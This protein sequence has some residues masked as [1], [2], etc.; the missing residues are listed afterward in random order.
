MTPERWQE[1]KTILAAALERPPAERNAYLDKAC[2]EPE[3]RREV[4]L[5][6]AA[7]ERAGGGFLERSPIEAMRSA[8]SGGV[9]DP[10]T[11]GS[12]LGPY[13]ILGALGAG[14]MGEVYRARDTRLDRIVA[15]KVLSTHLADRPEIRERFE[16]EARTI[17][18]LNHSHICT[19][20][21][22]G[23][24][25]GLDFLV[26][27]YVEGETL[28]R[29]LAKGALPQQQVVEFGTQIADALDAAHAKGIIHRDIKP[30]NVVITARGRAKILDFGLAKLLPAG[31]PANLSEMAT[32]SGAEQLTRPGTLIGTV[33]YMSPEQVRGEDLDARSD[34]FSFGAVL[35]EMATGIAPFRGETGGVIVEA[36]LNRTPV[37]P[38][39]LN[40]DISPKLEEIILKALEKD[41]RLRYQHASEMRTDLQRLKRDSDP[42]R[43]TIATSEFPAKPA[44]RSTRRRWLAVTGAAALAI[45][46][47]AGGWFFFFRNTHALN[48]KDAIVLADFAN[49]TGDPVFDGTL[50]QGLA[51]QLGQSPFFNLISDDQIAQTLRLME[52]PS[53][54]P[55][56]ND[57]ARQ[58]CQRL[59]AIAVIGGSIASLGPQYVV[60]LSALKCNTGEILTE[61]QVTAD[62]KSQVLSALAQGASELR[63]KLGESLSSIQQYDVPLEQAT[64]SSLDALQAYTLGRKEMLVQTDSAAAIPLFERAISLDPNFAMAHARLGTCYSNLG[65]R[66]KAIEESIKAYQLVDRTSGLE[67]LYI[68]SHYYEFVTGDLLK[69]SQ[70]LESGTEIYPQTETTYITL[71]ATYRTLGEYD[72][73]LSAA[74]SGLRIN[75]ESGFSHEGLADDY[76]FLDRLD[77][78]KAVIQE[79]HALGLDPVGEHQVLYDIGFLQHDAAAMAGEVSWAAGKMQYD[80]QYLFMESLTAASSGLLKQSRDLADQAV[81]SA[82]D[83]GWR[84]NAGRYRANEALIEALFGNAAQA[85]SDARAALGISRGTDVE[86]NAALA[87]E[88]SADTGQAQ[89]LADDLAKRFPDDTLVQYVAL[90]ELR[91]EIEMAR[92]SPAQA[93]QLLEASAPYEFGVGP[94]CL[95]IFIRGRAYL[96]EHDGTSAAAE[97]Q[98]VLD[99]P[100]VVLNSPIGALA[101]LGLARAY[102]LHGDTA[103]ARAAYLDFFSLWKNADPDVPILIAARAEFGKLH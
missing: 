25:D 17:A 16:R 4:E 62:S 45:G 23:Q 46:L 50:R 88:L 49:S 26:M 15:I 28:A 12:K 6:I 3:V 54:A 27:E 96:A 33:A 100:G 70:A 72:K 103:K 30:A 48:N 31:G 90:P 55:L 85:Q 89:F 101:H 84:E 13:E 34:L 19:L 43:P 29:R 83:L 7:H 77:E 92:G 102:V 64:T 24:Q 44:K 2:T 14:G 51:V 81:T 18:S 22:I 47:A 74:Q 68:T 58:V 11:S 40:P 35:Y 99:H 5:L 91:A 69:T 65:E 59:G 80:H 76:L 60:G 52:Q 86:F 10:L 66:V 82:Q 93:I 53:S 79:S 39:R 75:P 36:I 98:K 37:A 78:A 71:G 41:K 21:D 73:A 32:V 67:K 57:L 20:H 38:V 56:T 87:S 9:G 61:E 63:G 95:P 97:F 8:L 1:V 42:G 94:Q